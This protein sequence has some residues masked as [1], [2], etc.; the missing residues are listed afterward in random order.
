M[1]RRKA[2]VKW[3]VVPTPG[4]LSNQMRPPIASTRR[5]LMLNR[6]P[7]RRTGAC[8]IRRL[9]R[10]HF[11]GQELRFGGMRFRR[12]RQT[13]DDSE[14]DR[15]ADA[16]LALEP[17]AAAHRIYQAR[18]DAQSQAGAPN[19]RVLDPSPCENSFFRA[20]VAVRRHAVPAPSADA[21]RQ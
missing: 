11:L 4:S 9:A 7:V 12:H 15:G 19:W 5:E 14:V 1:G 21:G 10:I 2:T 17:D 3:N 18:A 20:G 8:W 6:R 13:Q 16:G